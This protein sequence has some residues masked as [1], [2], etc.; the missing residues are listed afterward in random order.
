MTVREVSVPAT[1]AIGTYL[2]GANFGDAYQ[3][4]VPA[5]DERIEESYHGVMGSM[6]AWFSQLFKLRNM[7]VRPFGLEAPPADEIENM[8]VQDSYAV[9]DKIGVFY[10]Y[11]RTDDE[12]ITGADD[13]HLD[14]RLSLLRERRGTE[15]LFTVTTLVKTHNIFGRI[16]LATI[17]P[18]HRMGVKALL[19]N[20]AKKQS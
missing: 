7:I 12:L 17:M 20:W 5:R 8:T 13:K 16:Y 4:S 9:G 2:P 1:S 18:F 3:V 11:G 19:G 10:F 6:P 15:D 14:F